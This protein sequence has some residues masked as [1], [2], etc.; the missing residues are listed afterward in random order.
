MNET[1]KILALGVLGWG[2]TGNGGS[3]Q[4]HELIQKKI[5]DTGS[6][7]GEKNTGWDAESD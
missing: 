4:T 3:Q 7:C 2:D 6:S 5:P 1:D